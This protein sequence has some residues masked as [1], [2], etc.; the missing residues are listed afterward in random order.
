M[1]FRYLILSAVAAV[2]FSHANGLLI[3]L[4]QAQE[5]SS[6]IFKSVAM[7]QEV[8]TFVA[9]EH[10]T[11]GTVQIV[12]ENG[13]RYLDFDAAFK[14][15]AGPDLHVILHRAASLPKGGLQE[16]DYAIVSRLQKV[17]GKQRYAIPQNVNLA[18]YRSVAIWCR[19]FNATFGY[20]PL[21]NSERASQ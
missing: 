4:V 2:S 10:P 21:Q 17:S 7:A 3:N 16:Q 18:N 11:Q 19:Q 6:S 15:D 9:A 5:M 12:R 14:S 20:A 13:K 8:G 1:K